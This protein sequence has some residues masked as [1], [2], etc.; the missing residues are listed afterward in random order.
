M[1]LISD[2]VSKYLISFNINLA[3]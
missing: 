1:K 3:T 2:F